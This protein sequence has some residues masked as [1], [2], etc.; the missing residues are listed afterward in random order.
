MVQKFPKAALAFALFPVL[1]FG[2]A[3]PAAAATESA[4]EFYANKTVT[5]I[6][7]HGP[8]GGGD[9]AARVYAA[10]WSEV[11]GG[12]AMRVKNVTGGG[13]TVGV[14]QVYAAKPDGLTI[15]TAAWGSDLAMPHLFKEKGRR[16]ELAKFH[17]LGAFAMEG[18]AVGMSSRVPY[19]SRADLKK[20]EGLK[21]GAHTPASSWS[22][23]AALI[24]DIFGLKNSRIV[25]GFASTPDVQLSISKGEL[26]GQI[27]GMSVL[28][29]AI[30]KGWMK[31]PFATLGHKRSDWFPDTP[32]VPELA[33]LTAEQDR[34]LTMIEKL[35]TGKIFFAPPGVPADR[36]QFLRKA[37]NKMMEL[38]PFVKQAMLRFEVWSPPRTS[39]QTEQMVKDLAAI[40]ESDVAKLIKMVDQRVG[41]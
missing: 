10:W 16:Y 9:Y 19:A 28:K 27:S 24:S 11:S 37:F 39:E 6:V 2:I 29:A 21:F 1:L 20:E 12:G 31:K 13:G 17:W 26:S 35:D 7:N 14:N 25:V 32:A 4:A 8:G 22:L 40:D 5:I 3:K 23:N 36:V 34:L 15:G 30:D 18:S 33:K 41:R 38:K